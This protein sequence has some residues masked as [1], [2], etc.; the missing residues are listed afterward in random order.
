MAAKYIQKGWAGYLKLVVPK[1]ASEVQIAE[2]RQAFFSGACVL[3]ESILQTLNPGPI[4]TEED[5]Q[6]MRDI[7]HE[8]AAFGQELDKRIFKLTEH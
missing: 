4:E 3:F 7:G 2:T 8:I 1:D 5:M 6:R